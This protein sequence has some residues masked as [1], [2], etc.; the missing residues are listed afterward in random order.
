[1][2]SGGI[3]SRFPAA[4]T[5]ED[6]CHR[7]RRV[8]RGAAGSMHRIGIV[9][10]AWWVSA[11]LFIAVDAMAETRMANARLA[12]VVFKGVSAYPA[13]TLLS[14]YRPDLGAIL[15]DALVTKLEG[16]LAARYSTDGYL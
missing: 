6:A 2:R 4:S 12:G 8:T 11:C 1:M 15:D 3:A 16:A 14:L 5:A 13:E 10:R 7:S 9:A